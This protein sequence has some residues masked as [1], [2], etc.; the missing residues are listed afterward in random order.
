MKPRLHIFGHIHDGYGFIQKDGT[1]YVNAS[2]CDEEYKPLNLP[3]IVEIEPVGMP[4]IGNTP[5]SK[6]VARRAKPGV[7][8]KHA[9]EGKWED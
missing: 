5:P 6:R 2:V 4:K 9:F 3:L 7:S 8:P 1:T